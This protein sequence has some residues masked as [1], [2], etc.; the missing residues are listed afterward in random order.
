MSKVNDEE[1]LAQAQEVLKAYQTVKSLG[2]SLSFATTDTDTKY[3][4][5]AMDFFTTKVGMSLDTALSMVQ[6]KRI[7]TSIGAL[8][9]E[10][11]TKS[12]M[13][14]SSSVFKDV[15]NMGHVSE[16]VK[17]GAQYYMSMDGMT[18]DLA[19]KAMGER[20]QEDFIV[21]EDKAG[22]KRAI[23]KLSGEITV[24]APKFQEF[25]DTV[26]NTPALTEIAEEAF[27]EGSV[28]TLNND[29]DNPQQVQ[30]IITNE[31]GTQAQ[32][33][34]S[35]PMRDIDSL[36]TEIIISNVLEDLGK[37]LPSDLGNAIGSVA[38]TVADTGLTV[39]QFKRKY[40]FSPVPSTINE[41]EFAED[42][43]K[44]AEKLIAE[45][46]INIASP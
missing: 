45:P 27:G 37:Q 3:R 36:N 30:L 4:L 35:I 28:L 33:L 43:L 8:D 1:T 16:Y 22:N 2:A 29:Y 7:P 41:D 10:D 23:E 5:E 6:G 26:S 21:L 9:T 44:E 25:L 39:E 18:R 15:T 31:S 38:D 12:G 40:P 20:V 17:Q 24:T 13:W 42:L 19:L 11:L 32:S 34:V 46:F 14:F